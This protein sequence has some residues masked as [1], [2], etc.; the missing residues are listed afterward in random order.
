M[1]EVDYYKFKQDYTNNIVNCSDIQNVFSL[2][3]FK[4]DNKEYSKN[5]INP[6]YTV[7][8]LNTVLK[9]IIR[10]GKKKNNDYHKD[11]YKAVDYLQFIYDIQETNDF[12]CYLQKYLNFLS[13]MTNETI[14]KRAHKVIEMFCIK[15]NIK[16]K[17]TI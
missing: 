8:C 4:I 12:L 10:A 17:Y 11:M 13:M 6:M 5:I 3:F 2:W 15:N 16:N 9:Y 7:F 14:T 1:Q